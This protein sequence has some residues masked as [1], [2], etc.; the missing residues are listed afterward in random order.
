MKVLENFERKLRDLGVLLNKKDVSNY[1]ELFFYNYQAK[2]F[3][4]L[5][6]IPFVGVGEKFEYFITRTLN[7]FQNVHHWNFLLFF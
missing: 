7:L 2:C 5:K 3:T 6:K 4:H 1:I